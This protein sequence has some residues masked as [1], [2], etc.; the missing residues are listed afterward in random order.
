MTGAAALVR[1]SCRSV[2]MPENCALIC[3]FPLTASASKPPTMATPMPV[4][5]RPASAGRAASPTEAAVATAAILTGR[6]RISGPMPANRWA[7]KSLANASPPSLPLLPAASEM[8]P[9]PPPKMCPMAAVM[10]PP[11]SAAPNF[12]AQLLP[13]SSP[14][15]LAASFDSLSRSEVS[16]SSLTFSV[17]VPGDGAAPCWTSFTCSVAVPGC[18]VLCPVTTS[19]TTFVLVDDEEPVP[20]G[21]FV[22]PPPCGPKI[23]PSRPWLAACWAEGAPVTGCGE[24]NAFSAPRTEPWGRRPEALHRVARDRVV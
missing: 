3:A 24:N 14:L 7:L 1:V 21:M 23:L 5:I 12:D 17:P 6:P 18:V 16:A 19:R 15:L 11:V 22:V 20:P 10:P 2:P 4:P 8:P 13:A 9:P